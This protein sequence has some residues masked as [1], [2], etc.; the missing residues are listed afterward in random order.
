MAVA[1]QVVL[2]GRVAHVSAVTQNHVVV[3]VAVSVS[4]YS[5]HPGRIRRWDLDDRRPRSV[6]L[7]CQTEV[8]RHSHVHAVVADVKTGEGCV[9]VDART[10]DL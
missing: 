1:H 4:T 2:V 8:G 5:R 3:R 7:H 10:V 9:R 6:V